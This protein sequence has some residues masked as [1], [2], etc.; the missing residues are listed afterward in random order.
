MFG[1][2]VNRIGRGSV[3]TVRSVGMTVK[4]HGTRQ[5]AWGYAIAL[6]GFGVTTICVLNHK[7]SAKEEEGGYLYT[8]FVVLWLEI[9]N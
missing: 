9:N 1:T 7:L 6:G 4:A 2:F 8:W 5:N 3:K